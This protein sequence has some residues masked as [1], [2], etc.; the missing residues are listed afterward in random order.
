MLNVSC[1]HGDVDHLTVVEAERPGHRIDELLRILVDIQRVGL[2]H[3]VDRRADQSDAMVH[4]EDVADVAP[5]STE[6][7]GKD[8]LL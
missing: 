6:Q 1:A 8:L 5:V 2:D 3:R 4:E 7:E